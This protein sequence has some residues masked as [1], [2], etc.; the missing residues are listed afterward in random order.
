MP[1]IKTK[2]ELL[3]T[4]HAQH[5]LLGD[6]LAQI[7]LSRHEEPGVCRKWSIKDLLAHLAAWEQTFV[8][9]YADRD[10]MNDGL[11]PVECRTATAVNAYNQEIYEKY[12]AWSLQDVQAFYQRS[13]QH[14]IALIEQIPEEDFFTPHRYPWTGKWTLKTFV[15][16]NTHLHYSWARTQILRWKSRGKPS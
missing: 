4:I 3:K 11:M 15:A 7:E 8:R 2:A 6:V 1:A 10:Q 13:F 5:R 12:R 14:M 16:A 9:W